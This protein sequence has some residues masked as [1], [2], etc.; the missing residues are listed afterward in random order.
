MLIRH[1]K[2]PKNAQLKNEP[3]SW[4]TWWLVIIIWWRRKILWA[5]L[6]LG[7]YGVSFIFNV[8]INTA[9]STCF[10]M[11]NLRLRERL[12]FRR[13]AVGHSVFFGEQP[14]FYCETSGF[15]IRCG[16]IDFECLIRVFVIS[17]E[18]VTLFQFL[19]L[20]FACHCIAN[21]YFA[22]VGS[23]WGRFFRMHHVMNKW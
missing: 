14:C 15:Q 20:R 9:Y 11:K 8:Y 6:C 12:L 10:Y 3:C 7:W 21:Q 22:Q 13:C 16:C 2:T 23:S 19:R 4:R 5:T 18:N 17:R 1:I